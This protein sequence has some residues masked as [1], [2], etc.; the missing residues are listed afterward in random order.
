MHDEEAITAQRS[1]GRCCDALRGVESLAAMANLSN[2]YVTVTR[3]IH[4]QNRAAGVFD[5]VCERFATGEL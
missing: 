1:A 5:A 3:A 2:Q 4:G